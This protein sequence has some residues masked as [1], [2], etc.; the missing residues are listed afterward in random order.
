M[1]A[2]ILGGLAI[3]TLLISGYAHAGSFTCESRDKRAAE[4]S[5]PDRGNIRLQEQLSKAQ[6]VEG[7]TWGRTAKGVYVN[8]G[9][10]AR[11]V[12][13]GGNRYTTPQPRPSDRREIDSQLHQRDR[14]LSAPSSGRRQ[15]RGHADMIG[16]RANIA[17]DEL[18]ARG[19]DLL[20]SRDGSDRRWTYFRSP[21]RRCLQAVVIYGRFNSIDSVND[22]ECRQDNLQIHGRGNAATSRD[23]YASQQ[24]PEYREPDRR[25]YDDHGGRDERHNDDR[26][27]DDRRDDDR[28]YDSRRGSDRYDDLIGARASAAKAELRARG[29][30]HVR[31]ERRRS[32]EWV[33]YETPDRRRCVRATLSDGRYRDIVEREY[34]DC[35]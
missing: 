3:A 8:G 21:D 20:G 28:S 4:C 15:A 7:R 5:A 11:F 2:R 32:S 34:A 14:G 18:I 23:G 26:Y 1:H 17:Q 6:C 19:Y 22:R 16:E 29:Y 9:C 35:R 10:R 13:D 31:T 33:Y 24:R 27:R 25:D 12:T 30:S